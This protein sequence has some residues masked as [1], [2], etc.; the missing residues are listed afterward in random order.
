MRPCEDYWKLNARTVPD[1]YPVPYIE[2]FAQTLHGKR[3]FTTI[4][5]V[6]AYNQI[7]INPADI[8]KT[9][10]TTSFGMYE[11]QYMPFGLRNTAQTDSNGSLMKSCM[12]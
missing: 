3:I 12:D 6:R 1:R 10:I 11:F 8:S 7:P 5:L 4:N 9:A 2:D